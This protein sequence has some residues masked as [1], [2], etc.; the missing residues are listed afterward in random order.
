[1]L[2]A[3]NSSKIKMNKLAGTIESLKRFDAL[4]AW[5]IRV[6]EHLLRT[7][8]LHDE[9]AQSKWK[10]GDSV[11]VMFKE[12]EVILVKGDPLGIS[13]RN[14]FLGQVRAL[15]EMNPLALVSLDTEVGQIQ[16]IV[17]KEAIRE[18]DLSE[19]DSVWAMVKA[20]EI[21]LI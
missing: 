18:L 16:S 4:T 15:E 5:E 13:L 1:M 3:K 8:S 14:R 11:Q 10:H 7:V 19:G 9:S 21:I 12:T 6:G 20:N 17:T 2:L